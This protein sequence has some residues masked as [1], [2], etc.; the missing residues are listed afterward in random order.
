MNPGGPGGSGIDM[1]AREGDALRV[2]VDSPHEAQGAKFYD[3]ISFGKRGL[4]AAEQF[5]ADISPRS[6]RRPAID[7][8]SPLLPDK[9]S[10]LAMAREDE[11]RR[12]C[13]GIGCCIG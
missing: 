7:T 5:I 2:L 11:R 4:L 1:I 6:P 13:A 8:K 12:L 9:P 3:L 10:L